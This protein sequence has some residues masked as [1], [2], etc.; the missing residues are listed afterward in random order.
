MLTRD[1]LPSLTFRW[2]LVKEK[3]KRGPNIFIG[4]FTFVAVN[5]LLPQYLEAFVVVWLKL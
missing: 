3:D 5:Y 2:L 1:R 4:L